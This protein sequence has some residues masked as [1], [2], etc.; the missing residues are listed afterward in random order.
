MNHVDFRSVPDLGTIIRL[1][2]QEYELREAEPTRRQDGSPTTLLHWSTVCP[3]C[4][5]EFEVI[6][7]LVSS[8]LPRRCRI[9]RVKRTRPIKGRRG[10][11]VK[12]VVV[13]P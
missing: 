12:V 7:G 1:D 10:R 13:S 8:A 2:E 6:T 3:D 9:C 4:R 5:A 11:K